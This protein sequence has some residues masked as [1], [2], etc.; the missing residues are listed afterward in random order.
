MQVVSNEWRKHA[1]EKQTANN[2]Q[3]D[4]A[5]TSLQ[6]SASQQGSPFP[7]CTGPEAAQPAG[8]HGSGSREGH[9]EQLRNA[10][11]LRAFHWANSDSHVLRP[12][13]RSGRGSGCDSV[14]AELLEN[15]PIA[16]RERTHFVHTVERGYLQLLDFAV[17]MLPLRDALTLFLQSLAELMNASNPFGE[18]RTIHIPPHLHQ[19]LMTGTTSFAGLHRQEFDVSKNFSCEI[20]TW[21]LSPNS[22]GLVQ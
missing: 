15:L 16:N 17:D 20:S 6:T 14:E 3:T 8:A 1:S 13:I 19:H 4:N 22:E 5:G 11:G 21:A 9:A 7:F 12:I 2:A 10:F 18:T